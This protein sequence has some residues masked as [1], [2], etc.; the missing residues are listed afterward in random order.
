MSDKVTIID[1]IIDEESVRQAYLNIMLLRNKLETIEQCFKFISSVNLLNAY[2][3]KDYALDEI[4]K[5]YEFKKFLSEA[6]EDMIIKNIPGIEI[7]YTRNIVY[8]KIKGY[9]FSFHH[10]SESDIIKNYTKTSKNKV[11][12]WSGIRLQPIALS[13]FNESI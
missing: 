3:K 12:E 1:E 9:Q 2:V 5:N 7:Y 13:I 11:Q 4:K 6:I 10:I 8:I